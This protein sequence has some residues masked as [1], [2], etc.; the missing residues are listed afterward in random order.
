MFTMSLNFCGAFG[1]PGVLPGF[2]IF[3]YRV[4]PLTYLIDS[5]LSLG[6]ANN[7]VVCA[8]YE[9]IKFFPRSGETCGEY[10][11]NYISAKGG[12]ILDPNST[13]ECSF[14]TVA[15]T[16]AY[17][18]SVQSDY[19]R[20]WRNFGFFLA[21]IVFNWCGCILLYWL[22]RVPKKRSRVANERDPDSKKGKKS[23]AEESKEH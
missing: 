4:S 17:L 23:S 7:K 20:R 8:N 1:G 19:S 13:K 5:F 9:Y 6:L 16:N 2:W 14:C 21:F 18:A 15:E 10:M 3:M 12:Y 22:V 11:A